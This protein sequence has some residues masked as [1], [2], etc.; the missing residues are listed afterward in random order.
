MSGPAVQELNKTITGHAEY[1]W[2]FVR[3]QSCCVTKVIVSVIHSVV[4]IDVSI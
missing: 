2:Y 1:N 4:D 3:T